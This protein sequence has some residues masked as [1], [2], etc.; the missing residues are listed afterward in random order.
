[1]VPMAKLD[2]TLTG[3]RLGIVRVTLW[4]GLGGSSTTWL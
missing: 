3:G 1:M 2:L 4:A